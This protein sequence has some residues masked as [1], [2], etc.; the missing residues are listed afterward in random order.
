V[1][2]LES[3]VTLLAAAVV[4]VGGCARAGTAGAVT[5]VTGEAT[6]VRSGAATQQPLTFRDE[7]HLGDRLATG[8]DSTAR[9]LLGGTAVLTMSARA[10]LQ[11]GGDAGRPVLMQDAGTIRYSI[12]LGRRPPVESFE[13]RTPNAV[14]RVGGTVLVVDVRPAAGGPAATATSVCVQAGNVVVSAGDRW[15]QTVGPAECATITGDVPGPITPL[16]PRFPRRDPDIGAPG[17]Q[18]R[19][20]EHATDLDVAWT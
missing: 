12:D 3:G 19:R 10:V 7:V 5:S 13:I 20:L 14:A 4:L 9:V 11:I 15:R 1:H 8:V 18:P 16:P 17:G 2:C 6:V